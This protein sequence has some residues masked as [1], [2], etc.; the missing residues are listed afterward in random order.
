MYFFH[1]TSSFW[2]NCTYYGV[3]L[4]LRFLLSRTGDNPYKFWIIIS[5]AKSAMSTKSAKSVALQQIVPLL[6]DFLFFILFNIFHSHFLL[7]DNTQFLLYPRSHSFCL[8]VH[9]IVS[10]TISYSPNL[11]ISLRWWSARGT[12]IPTLATWFTCSLSDI[13]V[14]H[15]K[16]RSTDLLCIHYLLFNSQWDFLCALFSANFCFSTNLFL[17]LICGGIYLLF[18]VCAVFA[19]F[20]VAYF[21]TFAFIV[22]WW[23][24]VCKK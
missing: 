2:V 15:L 5:F 17:V 10:H 21:Q 13:F 19:L 16:P 4:S 11:F 8:L 18:I 1:A 12:S 23:L 7:V 20:S 9:S 14:W 22:C 3:S 24:L 6:S